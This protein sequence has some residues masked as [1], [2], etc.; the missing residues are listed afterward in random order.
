MRADEASKTQTAI[1]TMGKA[2]AQLLNASDAE[3][4]RTAAVLAI[5]ALSALDENIQQLHE[6]L[7]D[8]PRVLELTS[9]LAHIAPAKME[10]IKAVRAGN[11]GNARDQLRAMEPDMERV[12]QLSGEVVQEQQNRL[13]AAV[14]DQRKRGN[15]T[16]KALAG[17]VLG[18]ILISILAGWF[19]ER[20]QRAKEGAEAAN[21]SKS[22]F[23]ANMS[24]EIRTPMNGIIGM[25][26]LALDTELSREQ[27]DYLTMVKSSADSLLS[28]LNDIL[29]FSKIEAGKL[30]VETIDFSLRDCL[31]DAMK[32]LSLRADQRG[33]ELACHVLPDVPDNL[34]G[35]PTRLRQ[36]VI[37]LA[38]NAIKF[39]SVG[40]V[41]LRVEKGE[42]TEH[43]AV[44][45]FA[46]S[47]TG[48]GIPLDKQK[49]IFEA[50]TQA[51]SSTTRKFGGTGLGL[52]ISKR[53]IDVMGGR[54]WVESQPGKGSIFRFTARFALRKIAPDRPEMSEVEL[55][56][57]L[58]VLIADDNATNRKILEEMARSWH[59]NPALAED[60]QQALN[61]VEHAN[62]NATPFSLVLLD[63]QMP[64]LGGFAV[65]ERIQ[66]DPKFAGPMVLML[67]SAGLRGDAARCR[68]LG[69]RAYL[70]KPIKRADLLETIRLAFGSQTSTEAGP[71]LITVH[72]LR[73]PLERLHILL[74]EDNA[75][76]QKLA[77]RV[78]EKRGHVVVVAETGKVAVETFEKQP[79]DLI[80]MDIQMPVMDGLEATLAIRLREKQSGKRIPIIAMTASAMVGDKERCLEAGMD[81]Y[82]SKPLDTRELFA[83]IEECLPSEMT[84]HV[85]A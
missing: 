74:A 77:V 85:P 15:S 80:L 18:G 21:R 7:P 16:I 14:A 59:M 81:G 71:S 84:Q 8:N 41:V 82:V 46:V 43:E 67:T 76:N 4:R 45:H 70:P 72:S 37:N 42:A 58:P 62:L 13:A 11:L 36:I 33:L 83:V 51:D 79:F 2:Q 6:A 24:H 57:G 17:T 75:V 29:D 40:E 39:T 1:L 25:T 73:E 64:G 68:E 55:L 19:A 20:L 5:R 3:E 69:I 9:L 23:L 65:A 26:E 54:I 22:E 12:V 44:L 31:G 48:V 35:D 60:G 78:L 30:V 50:F 56:R 34:L 53:I 49:A 47:D 28:L 10:V 32:V 27:R 38:G 52:A 61:M 63:A 66:K